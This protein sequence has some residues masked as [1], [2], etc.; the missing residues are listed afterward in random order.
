MSLQGCKFN[1]LDFSAGS[2]YGGG[3]AGLKIDLRSKGD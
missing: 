3:R 1:Q 2:F